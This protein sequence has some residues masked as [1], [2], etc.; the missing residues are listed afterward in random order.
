MAHITAE[1]LEGGLRA[2]KAI[3]TVSAG[4]CGAINLFIGAVRNNHEG[5]DVT[6]LTYDM[7][8]GL[9]K[10]ELEKIAT[11]ALGALEGGYVYVA[12]AYGYLDVGENSVVIAVASPHRAEGFV[13]T[14]YII[15]EIKKRLPVWKKEHYTSGD[16]AWLPGHSLAKEAS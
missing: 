12:H 14:R 1:V 8:Q 5:K 15:E 16:S 3:E 7:H 9:T 2:E 4:S 10:S 11:E 6:G 13:A